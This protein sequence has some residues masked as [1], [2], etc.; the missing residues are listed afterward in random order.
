[1]A[2][3]PPLPVI[4]TDLV[5]VADFAAQLA[6]PGTSFGDVFSFREKRHANRKPTHL[7][8]EHFAGRWAAKEAF[9]KAWSQALYGRPPVVALERVNWQDIEVVADA[10][11]RVELIVQGEMKQA[12]EQSL[13]AYHCAISISHDG[14]FAT[15]SC[16]LQRL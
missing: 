14:G 11:G 4:G 6:Q 2:Y 13:G 16:I 9:I 1:M 3:D 12:V 8:H 10:W 7:R 15:A 5:C